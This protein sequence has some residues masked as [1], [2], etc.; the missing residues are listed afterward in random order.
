VLVVWLLA[1]SFGGPTFGKLSSVSTN[2]QAAYLPASSESTVVNKLQSQFTNSTSI[3]AIVVFASASRIPATE[4]PTYAKLTTAFG[5]VSGVHKPKPPATTAIAGPIPSTDGKAIEFIVPVADSNSVDTIVADLRKVANENAPAGTAVYVTGPAGLT[6]DLVSAF[7]GIDGILLGVA[8]AAVFVILLLV[9]RSIVLPFLVLFTSIFALTAAILIVFAM[10]SWGWITLSGQSQGILSILVI[11]A[12]TDYSLLLV[13]RYRE[14][15]GH[16]Q[17]KWAAIGRAW[18][19]ALEPIVASGATVIIA[20]LCLLFSDLNSNKSL[21]PIAAIGIVFSLLSALTLLPMLLAIFG[22]AAF[23]PFRPK[24]VAA[25]VADAESVGRTAAHPHPH[26]RQPHVAGLAG[27]TGLWLRVGTVI[28]RRPR[29]TWVVA[30][31]LLG[32]FALGLPQLKANGVS[33]TDVVLTHSNAADG[34]KVLARHFA[35]GSGSPIVIVADASQADVVLAAVRKSPGISAASFYVGSVNPTSPAGSAATPIVRDDKVLIDATLRPQADSDAAQQ[36]VRD[37]RSTLPRMDPTVL[38]GGVTAIALDTNTTAQSDLLK[39]IPIVLLVILLILMLL[40]RSILAP[41]LLIG[42]VVVSYAATLGVAAVVFNHVFRFP[43]A[44][45]SVPL[46]GFVFLVALGVDY[47]IFLM[48]RVREESL[49]LGTRPGI[50]QGLGVTGS[51][52][53]SAGVVLAATFA[54]LAVIPILFLVQIAF[55]VAFGVLLDT[56]VVRSLLVPALSY[57]I[58]RAIWWPSRLW[59]S[60]AASAPLSSHDADFST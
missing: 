47:N 51:V 54:A 24:V 30:L 15:L 45:A 56:I 36:V 28:A 60:S 31:I 27:I 48:T 39:I 7:G 1:A 19:A 23:W 29:A 43:G 11:G 57:D 3:P 10:A 2:D 53:T 9:Y 16:V 4:L 12:A 49:K 58:G 20:L 35:A 41:L 46:F 18:H 40:L 44:D 5:S 22:R 8:V 34:Q 26:R 37:L 32:V 55:I 21:G 52:I 38:V 50:L 42:S 14:A 59:S 33:Q 13:A 6:A 17:S 25:S